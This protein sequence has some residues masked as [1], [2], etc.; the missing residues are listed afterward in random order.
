A[1]T[2]YFRVADDAGN[3]NGEGTPDTYSWLFNKDTVAPDPP[4]SFTALPGHDKVHLTWSNPT[5]DPTFDHVELRRVAWGDYPE[6]ITPPAYPA[7]HTQGAHVAAVSG[8]S[9]D[10]P[11]STRD[12]YY[13]AGFSVDL[14]GNV[15]A[16]DAGA[17]DRSTS[18]WLGDIVSPYDGLVDYTD[19]VPFSSAFGTTDGGAGWNNECDF[20]PTDDWSRLGI[21]LPDDAIDF[22]DLMIFSM[23]YGNVSPLGHP[24]EFA[25]RAVESLGDLVSVR[26][27]PAGDEADLFAVVLENRATSLKG[28]RL[29]VAHDATVGI[30]SGE[31]AGGDC[32]FGTIERGGSST[33]ICVA[34]LG[35]GAAIEKSGAIALVRGAASCGLVEVEVRDVGNE[36]VE[37]LSGGDRPEG[38]VPAVTKLFGNYPNPFNPVTTI[39]YDVAVPQRV[40]IRIYDAAG[41]LVRV[42]ADGTRAPGSY[43]I[44]WNGRNDLGTSTPS[45][46]YFCRMTCGGYVS[47]HKMILLR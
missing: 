12:I 22:E 9:H 2:V 29:I 45:G 17:A 20:G 10:D 7:D 40:S 38:D 4:T 35:V 44:R 42:L 14:A 33:E 32:F 25:G 13:F 27:E 47:T 31:A 39:R 37:L 16:F 21:P 41:R 28:V 8:E 3:W 46:V 18:Y 11:L 15:S 34:A 19:L 26:L 23:N 43:E 30:Q 1:H 24:L 5:G 36:P 6:Y